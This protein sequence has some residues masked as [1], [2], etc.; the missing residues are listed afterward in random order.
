MIRFLLAA[1]R[2]EQPVGQTVNVTK[3]PAPGG[4]DAYD[5]FINHAPYPQPCVNGVGVTGFP[6]PTVDESIKGLTYSATTLPGSG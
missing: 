1:V 6:Q 5:R 3:L 2:P 4:G